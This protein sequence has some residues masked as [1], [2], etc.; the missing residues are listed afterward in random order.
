MS[1]C[2]YKVYAIEQ[3]ENFIK[4]YSQDVTIFNTKVEQGT[5]ENL[6]FDGKDCAI[7]GLH[8]CGDLTPFC[9]KAFINSSFYK[10]LAIASCCYHK[11]TGDKLNPMSS[12]FK[13]FYD[14]SFRR[15]AC[16]RRNLDFGGGGINKEVEQVMSRAIAEVLNVKLKSYET[17]SKCLQQIEDEGLKRR[18]QEEYEMVGLHSLHCVNSN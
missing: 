7:I 6:D 13:Y 16:E 11:M 1:K 2:G 5:L 4:N 18:F 10:H 8:S 9:I 12:L 3:N 15:L 14:I 17:M